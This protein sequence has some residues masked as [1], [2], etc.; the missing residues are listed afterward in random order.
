MKTKKTIIINRQATQVQ[1]IRQLPNGRKS[2]R[3]YFTTDRQMRRIFDAIH[4]LVRY[5]QTD[6]SS[7]FYSDEKRYEE[8]L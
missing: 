5:P 7:K 6:G 4:N 1:V 2:H 3:R 8:F